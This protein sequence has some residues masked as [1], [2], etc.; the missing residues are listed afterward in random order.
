MHRTAFFRNVPSLS[1]ALRQ[2]LSQSKL[3]LTDNHEAVHA[4]NSGHPVSALTST[5]LWY[6]TGYA[7]T[8]ERDQLRDVIER[9]VQPLSK[10]KFFC[11]RASIATAIAWNA[12][13][14]DNLLIRMAYQVAAQYPNVIPIFISYEDKEN[15]QYSPSHMMLEAL[16]MKGIP[17]PKAASQ[18]NLLTIMKHLQEHN[19]YALFLVDHFEKLFTDAESENALQIIRQFRELGHSDIGN[20][21]PILC[22]RGDTRK[23]CALITGTG[24]FDP[25]L[26][27]L[28]PL[29]AHTPSMEPRDFDIIEILSPRVD[30]E[31]L[32]MR[33]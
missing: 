32:K 7:W 29:V 2:L 14:M 26:S 4:G 30:Q 16:S 13:D 18:P 22:G 10:D 25:E 28:Y 19:L 23:F 15:H 9:K 6:M 5:L 1:P 21:S 3:I 17:V 33:F 20:I 12:G 11:S 31:S 24:R 27:K 8:S